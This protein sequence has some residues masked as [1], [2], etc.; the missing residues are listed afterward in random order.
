MSMKKDDN[1]E[2]NLFKWATKELSQ[3]AVVAWLLNNDKI[4]KDF[5][6][7]LC[8]SLEGE[9]FKISNIRT[10]YES[11]DVFVELELNDGKGTW[12]V[13]IEDKTDT[14]L[15]D[16][17]MLKYI[18]KIDNKKKYSK[19][20]FVLFKTG[21]VYKFQEEDYI[22][23][24]KRIENTKKPR[25]FTTKELNDTLD[26]GLLIT[27]SYQS[28]PIEIKN[29]DNITIE[30]IYTLDKFNKFNKFIESISDD[31]FDNNDDKTVFNY[32]N[33]YIKKQDYDKDC[34]GNYGIVNNLLKNKDYENYEFRIL[35]PGGA[36]KRNFE[37]SFFSENLCSINNNSPKKSFL[38]L[39]YIKKCSKKEYQ[40]TINFHLI[41]DKKKL[42]GYIPFSR[43]SQDNKNSFIGMRKD[44]KKFAEEIAEETKGKKGKNYPDITVN[45]ASTDNRL[46][47]LK[48]YGD[49][50]EKN[51]ENLLE[52][53]KML[54]EKI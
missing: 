20:I 4:G 52:I 29:T 17:Q 16:N 7:N 26:N 43:L 44:V 31:C 42:H 25:T 32:Y 50:S 21:Y 13:I 54:C 41:A 10:Q 23:W 36:G 11:I 24:Q 1:I 8:P 40:Y 15:H 34:N 47:V 22:K 2:N 33:G 46:Q 12:A 28:K 51:I 9:N 53:A 30:N 18:K 38:V 49:F 37:Y 5:I 3:D 39:P 6:K 14:Y 45:E 35:K 19:I 48:F 27:G